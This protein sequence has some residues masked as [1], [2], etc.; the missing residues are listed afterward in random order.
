MEIYFPGCQLKLLGVTLRVMLQFKRQDGGRMRYMTTLHHQI[1]QVSG[2]VSQGESCRQN[3]S[4]LPLE[5]QT[6]PLNLP[7]CEKNH[8]SSI[9]ICRTLLVRHNHMLTNR[10]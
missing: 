5:T 9:T 2:E 7:G 10:A 3:V 8:D 4:G 6:N 1:G